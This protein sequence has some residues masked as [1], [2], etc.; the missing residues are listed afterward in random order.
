MPKYEIQT[1]SIFGGWDN[2]WT[3]A[4]GNKEYFDS[5]HE[6]LNALEDFF[7]EAEQDYFNGYLESRY[8]KEDYRV[9]VVK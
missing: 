3:D 4:E 9:R 6:A 7:D 1:F 2:V 5:I 8:D